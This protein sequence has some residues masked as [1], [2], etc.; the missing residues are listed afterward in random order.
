[1]AGDRVPGNGIKSLNRM[2]NVME[3]EGS[4]L[5][6]CRHVKINKAL[7]IIKILQMADFKICGTVTTSSTEIH[8]KITNFD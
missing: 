4:R 8:N 7:H 6:H 2:K 3:F 5:E 1:L